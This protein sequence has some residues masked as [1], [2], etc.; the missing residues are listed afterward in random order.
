[1][2]LTPEHDALRDTLKR[3]IDKEV[4]PHVDEW[5]RAEVCPAHQVFNRLGELGM[6]GLT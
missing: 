4:N 3:F 1:M 5:E 6:L 2:Q